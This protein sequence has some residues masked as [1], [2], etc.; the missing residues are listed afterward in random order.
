MRAAAWKSAPA[1]GG[2]QARREP[3]NRSAEL[4]FETFADEPYSFFLDSSMTDQRLGRYAF[5][6]SR[7]FTVFEARGPRYTIREGAR[8]SRGKGDPFAVLARLVGRYRTSPPAGAP[9]LL[10]GA[11]GFVSYEA[12]NS[13]EPVSSPRSG[14][15]TR[16]T[17][18]ASSDVPDI[19]FAFYES[20]LAY[21]LA[22]HE[23]WA[24]TDGLR[25]HGRAFG[26]SQGERGLA[27]L[28]QA[29][30]APRAPYPRAPFRL[31]SRLVSN[32]TRARYVAAV[33]TIRRAIAR[34]DIYQ[35]NLTQRFSARWSGSPYELYRRLRAVSAAP[36]AA[37]L[38]F[39]SVKVLS[40]SPERFLKVSGGRVETRPIKGTRPRGKDR[41]SDK[42]RALE[43]VRSV[44]DF[45]E[46]VMIVDL[47]RNDLGRICDAGSVWVPEL[48]A[49]EVYPQVF[50]LTSTVE[51]RLQRGAGCVDVL[52]AGFPGGSITG[53][54]KIRA[55][56]I[57][58]GIEPGPRGIYTGALGYMDF[59]GS[60][61]L[62]I[63]IRTITL[64]GNSLSFGVG[65]GVVTDSDPAMEYEES[66]DKA[67]GML[68]ALSGG[69]EPANGIPAVGRKT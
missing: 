31:D 22:R 25:A 40:S 18:P 56:E 19:C 42:S 58:A 1:S 27:L 8:V 46:H 54:P 44:K 48:A 50:H 57:L 65:G 36:F 4:V 64:S 23:I 59:S 2:S 24:P 37:Y 67:R 34:G 28:A 45:A 21:D 69:G 30:T 17:R 35:A 5:M 32:L 33:E 53:A 66:L 16:L 47:E 60:A 11:V 39:G 3:A 29:R 9:P 26:V 49:L 15:G 41:A 6:G 55:R 62:S 12:G 63:V 52:R 7:P 38:N 10:A 13:L 51:G 14:R 61:D 43:L 20:V 68:E